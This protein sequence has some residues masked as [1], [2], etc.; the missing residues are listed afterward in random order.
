[1]KNKTCTTDGMRREENREN[2]ENMWS[3][4]LLVPVCFLLPFC[5]VVF[6]LKKV[7]EIK[8]SNPDT[9]ISEKRIYV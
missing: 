9:S 4:H 7:K 2:R 3:V 8:G 5:F 1:M 6:V